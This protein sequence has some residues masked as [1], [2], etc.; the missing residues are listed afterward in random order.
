[1][2][3]VHGTFD[4]KL[5]YYANSLFKNNSGNMEGCCLIYLS[6]QSNRVTDTETPSFLIPSSKPLTFK[7]FTLCSSLT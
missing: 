2:V 3:Q 1:M 5:P 7:V 4:E 6:Y